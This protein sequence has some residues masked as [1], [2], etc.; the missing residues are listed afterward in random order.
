MRQGTSTAW[1]IVTI[2]PHMGKPFCRKWK[3]RNGK[4][5]RAA[6]RKRYAQEYPDARLSFT[7][8]VFVNSYG[9]H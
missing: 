8:A 1:L 2:T 3:G 6:A 4:T 9:A 7:R 5:I